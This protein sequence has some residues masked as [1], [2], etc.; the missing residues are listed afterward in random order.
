MMI[1]GISNGLLGTVEWQLGDPRTAEARLKEAVRTQDLIGH[2]SGMLTSLEGLA[3]V[4]GSAGQLERAALLLGAGAALCQELGITLYPYGVGDEADLIERLAA[5][6]DRL[7]PWP[8]CRSSAGDLV[9]R[10]GHLLGGGEHRPVARR[11]L[12]QVPVGVREHGERSR[13]A[14][15]AHAQPARRRVGIDDSLTAAMSE[16]R[17]TQWRSRKRSWRR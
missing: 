17:K 13:A 4:A 6:P 14:T 16:G 3:W 9:Q 2:R 11:Q 12:A 10:L 7:A 15:S 5:P 8:R 1:R